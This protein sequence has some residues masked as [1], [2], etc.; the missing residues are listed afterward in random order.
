LVYGDYEC[1][2]VEHPELF[3]FKRSDEENTYWVLLN[4]SEY[5]HDVDVQLPENLSLEM[6]NYVEP[7]ASKRLRPWEAK[8][9]K[10][11]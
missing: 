9:L 10:E 7:N 4:F 2:Q 8:I 1:Y 6:N 5:H 3:L 11:R